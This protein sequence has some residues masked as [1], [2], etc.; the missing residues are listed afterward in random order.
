MTPSE[1][2]DLVGAITREIH[3][4][5][6]DQALEQE[7]NR[8]FGPESTAF[9]S[10]AE[11][12]AAAVSAGWMC[13]RQ[14]GGIQYGRVLKPG[15]ATHGFSVDVVEME[16]VVGPHHRHPN[17]EI[18]MIMPVSG[19]AAF[20]GRDAGWLVYGPGSAH[21][22]TVSGGKARVLYLLPQGAIEFDKA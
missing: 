16:N 2:T 11:A 1:F 21:R 4:R 17:G 18:D 8:R 3:G 22:P 7:L 14:A 9:R 19:A 5:S 12:C 10:L 13:N 20:D 15:E 6:L